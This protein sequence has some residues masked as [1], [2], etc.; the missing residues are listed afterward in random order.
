MH[1]FFSS[2][3]LANIRRLGVQGGSLNSIIYGAAKDTLHIKY[4]K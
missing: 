4:F 2:Q 3:E 1:I